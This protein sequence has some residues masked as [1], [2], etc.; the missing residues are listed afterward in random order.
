[1]SPKH[2]SIR[3]KPQT[4]PVFAGMRR[5]R[6]QE[7]ALDILVLDE[8]GW[9]IPFDSADV[10]QSGVF[11]CSSY[12]F[13]VGTEHTLIIRSHDSD[14]VVRTKAKVVRL[15]DGSVDGR[16]GMAY[17]FVDTDARN[18]EGMSQLMSAL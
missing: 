16:S 8:Q 9:E 14:V 1:M 11:L 10:S 6:R 15:D 5:H 13:D 2:Q 4:R 3:R 7:A 17:A 12:L 18:W